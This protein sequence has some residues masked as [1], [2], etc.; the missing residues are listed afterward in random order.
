MEVRDYSHSF[1]EYSPSTYPVPGSVLEAHIGETDTYTHTIQ[2]EVYVTRL[3]LRE[4][5]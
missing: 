5:E 4:E 2:Y 3:M 1:T